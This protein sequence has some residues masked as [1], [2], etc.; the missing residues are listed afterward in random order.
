MSEPGQFVQLLCQDDDVDGALRE[1]PADGFPS[2]QGRAF[3]RRTAY[4]RRPFSIADHVPCEHAAQ[5][6]VISHAIGPGTR[7]LE[8]LR[9]DDTLNITGPLG[10]GF[11]IPA[12][13]VPLILIGGGVGIPPLLYLTR[14]LHERGHKRVIVVVGARSADLLPIELTATPD[15]AG[16]PAP[17]VAY[18]GGARYATIIT[19]DDGTMGVHGLV[20]DAL[21]SLTANDNAWSGATVLACG[22]DAM[23]R[24]VAR[25]T[26]I[27]NLACQLC[28]ERN[29]GCGLGTCLSCIVRRREPG[30]ANGWRWA[31]ACQEGPVFERDDLLDY[32]TNPSA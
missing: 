8:T 12:P 27:L 9:P 30:A 17:C 22:P 19:T 5:L 6:T 11:R 4:L 16:A 20:T 21:R 25:E 29:M 14:R 3:T 28:I 26:Q 2:V 32:A 7:W 24:A 31:L 13:E 18:P 1:W 23:L 15:A 10:V